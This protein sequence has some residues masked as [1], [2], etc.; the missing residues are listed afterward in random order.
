MHQFV[1]VNGYGLNLAAT[2]KKEART[3]GQVVGEML[4]H[5]GHCAH[6]AQPRKPVH[7]I[8]HDPKKVLGWVQRQHTRQTV[9]GRHLRKDAWVALVGVSSWPVA[10]EQV[11]T[12]I[13]EANRFKIW[14]VRDVA[15]LR[16][17]FPTAAAFLVVLHTDENFFH[18]HWVVVPEHLSLTVD[19]H[20][21]HRAKRLAVAAGK[22]PSAANKDYCAAM[23]AWQDS[24][25]EEV[26]EPCGLARISEAPRRRVS[27]AS[28]RAAVA[29]GE[30]IPGVGPARADGGLVNSHTE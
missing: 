18:H 19:Y 15:W 3:F 1:H 14:Q 21:G 12:S 4:R 5:P 16:R 13:A 23:R 22:M 10:A 17:Q 29:A 24:Y 6:V 8:G 26:G 30:W 7:V 9:N 11:R 20:P 25:F 28:V 27:T 2:R